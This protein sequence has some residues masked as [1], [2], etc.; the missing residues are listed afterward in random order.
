[1]STDKN[2]PKNGSSATQMQEESSQLTKNWEGIT[3]KS[4]H[5]SAMSLKP[6]NPQVIIRQMDLA[7][8]LSGD[9]P[10]SDDEVDDASLLLVE[11]NMSSA[12]TML[13]QNVSSV[14]ENAQVKP[15]T[16]PE[17]LQ[18]QGGLIDMLPQPST[19]SG[20]PKA[21][22]PTPVKRIPEIGHEGTLAFVSSS[23]ARQNV[24]DAKPTAQQSTNPRSDQSPEMS[25]QKL[26]GSAL[27][28]E[29]D[30]AEIVSEGVQEEKYLDSS[31]A[32]VKDNMQ[33]QAGNNS[34]NQNGS[35]CDGKKQITNSPRDKQVKS[36]HRKIFDESNVI[37]G[38]INTDVSPCVALES[39]NHHDPI[40]MNEQASLHALA[41]ACDAIFF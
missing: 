27:S 39:T 9:I 35:K 29:N 26:N 30:G 16:A 5:K 20:S 37:D 38:N 14:F 32:N 24:H 41:A 25:K 12:P 22:A 19:S 10:I 3:M 33:T 11:Q 7:R 4:V 40:P 1:M 2:I 8:I 6:R 13:H 23:K 31:S 17:E 36:V 28:E 18:K 21:T 15:P 34:I